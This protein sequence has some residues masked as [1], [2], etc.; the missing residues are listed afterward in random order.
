MSQVAS[1]SVDLDNEWSYLKT[2]GD[3]AWK[4]FPSFLERVVPQVLDFADRHQTRL[5]LFVVGQDAELEKNRDVLHSLGSSRHEI[6]NHSFHHEPW[7]HH[8]TDAELKEEIRRAESAIAEVTGRLPRGFRGPGYSVSKATIR[9]L[10]E[11]GYDY[12]ASSLSSF[13]GPLARWFYFRSTTMDYEEREKR[14]QLFGQFRDV[15]RPNRPY[16]WRV[17]DSSTLL[18]IPVTT[19]PLLKVP[20]HATY[21]LQLAQFS[22]QA[23]QAYLRL[24]LQLCRLMRIQP[25]FLLHALDFLGGDDV[26]RLGFFPTM[27][28]DGETKR[29]LIDEYTRT[30]GRHYRLVA[31]D[32]HAQ[33][34]RTRGVRVRS[35]TSLP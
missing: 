13:I 1:L 27:N 4:G 17:D 6:G 5:T 14:D 20:I 28:M 30:I 9:A 34:A 10:V 16:N 19:M 35:T 23:S 2:Y 15:L 21:L 8:K 32:E 11:A 33:L 3:P 12:D 31:I 7:L 18:E 26:A 22:K 29:H 24:A 25:S